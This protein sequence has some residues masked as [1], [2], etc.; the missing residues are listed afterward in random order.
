MNVEEGKWF[1]LDTVTYSELAN[2][3]AAQLGT[4]LWQRGG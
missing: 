1:S 3:S 2:F 4:G